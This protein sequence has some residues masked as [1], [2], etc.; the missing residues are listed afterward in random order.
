VSEIDREGESRRG[1]LKCMGWAGTGL[2]WTLAGGVPT[3]LALDA[4]A[5]S[6]RTS[7]FSFVQISD[8]HIGF[9]KP[10]N[11]DARVTYREA[12]ARIAAL[13]TRPDFILHTGDVSQLSKPSQFDDA[14][15]IIQEAG[16]PVF[17]VPGEHDVLDEGQGQAFLERYAKGSKGAGW[18]SFD[19]AGV[20]F[21][22]LVNVVNLKAGGAG[23]LGPEQL[24]WLT[25]DLAAHGASTPIVVFTHIPLWALY[26]DWGWS[27]EDAGQ[28]LALL[29]RFGSVTVLNGHIH[30]VQQKV[31]GH[32]A[33][34]TARSTAFPQAAPGAPGQTPGPLAVP[35]DQ[36]RR[37]LGV[38]DVSFVAREHALAVTDQTLA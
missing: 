5:A 18:Y 26:P 15:Q 37:V 4:A 10:F 7:P 8:S 17:H 16:L 19:H 35:A 1:F 30:Q 29:R 12:V 14:D 32:V 2:V 6:R 21:V 28:A 20:H 34:Y 3:S 38:R 25:D 31:E 33:F 27:T 22:A 11:P 9:A 36:L 24:A 13:P 23:N